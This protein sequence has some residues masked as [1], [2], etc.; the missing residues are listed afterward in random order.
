[1]SKNKRNRFLF[2]YSQNGIYLYEYPIINGIKQY[3]QIRGRN[4]NNPLLLFVHGGPG[5]SPAGICD[6][7]QTGWEEKYT[8][9]NR[10]QRNSCKTYFANKSN[11]K[12]IA[13]TG[14]LED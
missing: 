5:S 10:D 8:V 4:R 2:P 7:V 11:A 14:T 3:V 1:M 6:E 13:G 12:V 9:V